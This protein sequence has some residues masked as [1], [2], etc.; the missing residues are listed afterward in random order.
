MIIDGAPVYSLLPTSIAASHADD[1]SPAMTIYTVHPT[2]RR[3]AG[4][5]CYAN[6]HEEMFEA[7]DLPTRER[8]EH[9]LPA[10]FHRVE[11]LQLDTT[12]LDS[13][14]ASDGILEF[15]LESRAA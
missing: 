5:C 2:R 4:F 12:P 7:T 10:Q 1:D 8:V 11:S 3:N 15:G 6:T 13:M 14:D 9:D